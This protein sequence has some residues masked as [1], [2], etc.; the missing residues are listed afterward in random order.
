MHA[1]CD[2]MQPCVTPPPLDHAP[3]ARSLPEEGEE[4]ALRHARRVLSHQH[5]VL[6]PDGLRNGGVDQGVHALEARRGHHGVDLGGGAAVVT[7]HEAAE[8]GGA[9]RL[10][11]GG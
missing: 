7:G 5:A 8:D 10:E 9:G 1:P 4:L 6:A 11:M 2:P 3:A